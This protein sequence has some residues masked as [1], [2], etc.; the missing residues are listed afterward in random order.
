MSSVIFV[1]PIEL[2]GLGPP[3]IFDQTV[4]APSVEPWLGER[5]D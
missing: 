3:E 2:G 4:I 1:A 5:H